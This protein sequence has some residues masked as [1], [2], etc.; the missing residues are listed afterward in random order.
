M[1]L[2][3]DIGNTRTKIG[4]FQ[5]DELVSAKIVDELTTSFVN[6]LFAEF[7]SIEK[8]IYSSV[9]EVKPE[10]VESLVS[11]A[12][13][14]QL[15]NKT[16][17]P[18]FNKYETPDTL[19]KDRVAGV[20]GAINL[21]PGKN[22]LVI[23]AGTCITY[24]L[25]TTE[26]E[27]LGGG[28]SPGLKM[29]FDAMHT[30]TGQ[31]PLVQSEIDKKPSLIGNTTKTSIESGVKNGILA[32]VDGIIDEYKKRFPNLNV[33]VTGGDYNYFDKYLK[34]NIFAAPNLV[35]IG[36]KKILDIR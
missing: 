7:C 24:D 3:I 35:L 33:V 8:V 15:T 34:N 10:I 30:F 13:T 11:Q 2:V 22:V 19:G 26:K 23:D 28:I 14:F 16:V 9:K 1:K 5:N 32:E 12:Q 31:L 36:L 18:F 20:A 17:L 25:V 21:F 6:K 27:Y 29:R 4:I